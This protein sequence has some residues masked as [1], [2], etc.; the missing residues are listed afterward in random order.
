[1]CRHLYKYKDYS[2]FLVFP[3]V[4][5]VNKVTQKLRAGMVH[6]SCQ[7]ET[8]NHHS[9]GLLGMPVREY[10]GQFTEARRPVH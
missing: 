2:M 8:L 4:W 9:D 6:L 5:I 3:I 7:L 1:M 10:L